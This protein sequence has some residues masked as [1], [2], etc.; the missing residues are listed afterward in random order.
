MRYALLYYYDPDRTTPTEGEVTEWMAFDREVQ[1]GGV[2]LYEV[3]LQSHLTA[4]IVQTRNGT[5]TVEPSPATTTGEVIA[6]F[7]VVDV[8]SPDEAANWAK[9]I[10][11]AKYGKVEMR[12]V[13][14]AGIH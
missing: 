5:T 11:A 12:P 7:Y 3:G 14:E 4:S 6:G 2:L 13:V 1:A 9:R 8:S 10:P